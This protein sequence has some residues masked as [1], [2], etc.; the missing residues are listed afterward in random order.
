MKGGQAS[1][2]APKRRIRVW[3]PVWPSACR[4]ASCESTCL[5]TDGHATCSAAQEEAIMNILLMTNTYL[6]HVGGVARSVASFAAEF[7]R[8]GHGVLVIAPEFEPP[9][10]GEDG[11]LRV[12]ALKH[13]RGTD[14]SVPVPTPGFVASA[15]DQ[16]APDVVHSHHPFLIGNTAL[17]I[18]QSRSLPLVFTHHTMYEQYPHNLSNP[19]E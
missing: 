19:D 11:V 1:A 4:D 9:V 8:Q 3:L 12:P 17:R 18:A 15:V 16:F 10:D 14:F 5:L 7:R 13:W 2:A 6:P